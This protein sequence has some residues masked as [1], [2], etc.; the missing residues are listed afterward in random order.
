MTVRERLDLL[1]RIR[2][3]KAAL[4]YARAELDALVR[5]AW[6]GGATETNLADALG[7]SPGHAWKR[8][9]EAGG[10]PKRRPYRPR[11]PR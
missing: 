2:Q 8:A 1:Q 10:R 5:R 9:Q 3:Q 11:T 7:C 4:D 6:D